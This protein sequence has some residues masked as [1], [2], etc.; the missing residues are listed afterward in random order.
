MTKEQLVVEEL[1]HQQKLTMA[2]LCREN[3]ELHQLQSLNE[4]LNNEKEGIYII[5]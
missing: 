2:M 4:T 3:T 5:Q 1:Y